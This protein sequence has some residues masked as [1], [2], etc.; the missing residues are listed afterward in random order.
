MNLH[1]DQIN[2]I[3]A[4]LAKAQG[5]IEG[6][7]KG[8]VNPAFRSKYA[9]LASVWDAAR[10]PL[11]SNGLSVVQIPNKT[12]EGVELVT[13]LLHSS[14]QWISSRYPI[15]PVKDDPQGM[16]S[17]ITYG[18]RYSLMALVGI[19]P[20][21][22]DGN[23]A[24]GRD[25]GSQETPRAAAQQ[26]RQPVKSE[27]APPA[28]TTAAKRITLDLGEGEIEEFP[29]T[30]EGAAKTLDRLE[31]LV[32]QD[33]WYWNATNQAV[34]GKIAKWLPDLAEQVDRIAAAAAP[35]VAAE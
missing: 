28:T 7:S 12:P 16:G 31:D 3:A 23:A 21:D 34:A 11:S 2:E 14:G 24:S 4:A 20:E 17:A 13:M 19:A 10:E 26:H 32:N 27:P 18:R 15:K 9:D 29:A 22:D 8:K 35:A 6:A 1:S 5:Q 30:P 33:R 25:G